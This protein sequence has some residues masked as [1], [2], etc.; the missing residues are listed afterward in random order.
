MTIIGMLISI[1][2]QS[3]A[4]DDYATFCSKAQR[5]EASTLTNEQ[6]VKVLCMTSKI[7][8]QAGRDGDTE[9]ASSC[10]TAMERVMPDF[11]RRFPGQVPSDV[12]RK[13]PC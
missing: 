11:D 12:V 8:V 13:A 10:M 6:Y 7:A 5:V 2:V 1:F 4:A 9:A 3:A